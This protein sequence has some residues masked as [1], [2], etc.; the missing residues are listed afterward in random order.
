MK[1]L[2]TLTLFLICCASHTLA[3]SSSD[4]YPRVEF[5]GGFSHNRI[6]TGASVV[7]NNFNSDF[8]GRT[9][10]NGFDASIAANATRHVGLKFNVSGYFKTGR[11]HPCAFIIPCPP[12]T[13]QGELRSRLY[14][15]VGGVQF[16]DNARE[17]RFKPFA[18]LMA[19][20]ARVSA[21]FL[22]NPDDP[23]SPDCA[24]CVDDTGFAAILG[25]GLDVRASRNIDVRL[26]QLDYNPTRLGGETQH[27]LRMGFGIVIH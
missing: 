14:N 3:Q 1:R 19:G 8:D 26:F 23:D 20:G 11:L 9:G 24:A 18:H 2:I 27:N 10:F 25:G 17:R 22:P 7:S 15:F 21:E 16:K 13:L 4:D 6:D 5:Y 12:D